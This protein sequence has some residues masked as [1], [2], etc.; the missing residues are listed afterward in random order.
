MPDIKWIILLSFLIDEST[1]NI[2]LKSKLIFFFLQ[3]VNIF[4][5]KNVK[6]KCSDILENPSPPIPISLQKTYH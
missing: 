1:F 6:T 2:K 4:I 5:L 3:N